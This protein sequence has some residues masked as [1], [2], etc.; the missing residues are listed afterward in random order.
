MGHTIKVEAGTEARVSMQTACDDYTVRLEPGTYPVRF[1]AV[2]GRTVEATE[3][4]AAYWIIASIPA[5]R[6]HN[7]ARFGKAGDAVTYHYQ[8]WAYCAPELINGSHGF[9]LSID[10]GSK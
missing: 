2:D 4:P 10:G 5:T 3:W 8:T 7:G 6:T 9:T 1:A